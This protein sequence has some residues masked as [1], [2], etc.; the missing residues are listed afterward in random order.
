[1]LKSTPKNHAHPGELI[2]LVSP[3]NKSYLFRLI[4][5]GQLHTHRGVV[6]HDDCI[7][8]PFGSIISSHINSTYILLQPTLGDLLLQTPRNTQ[9]MYPKDIGYIMVKMGIGPGQHIVEAGTGSGALTIALAWFVGSQGIVTTYETREEMQTLAR[10]NI[11]RLS[12]EGRVEFKKKDIADGFDENDVDAIFLDLPNPNDYLVQVR[13]SLKSGGS[14]GSILPT[15]N[16]VSKLLIALHQN[17]FGFVEV[18][19]IILRFYKPAF[20]RL[21]PTDRMVAHTGYLIFGRSLQ[22]DIDRINE[23]E[24]MEKMEED[25]HET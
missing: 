24:P 2:Q 19:E 12:L 9:I 18:C 15:T 14:F 13:K 5:G 1:M 3:T 17:G 6:N 10:K 16:Q 8:K 25:H 11:N 20:D 4:Q 23:T 22:I 7:D 21:R